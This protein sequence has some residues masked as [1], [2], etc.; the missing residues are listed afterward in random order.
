MRINW[1]GGC[2]PVVEVG[3]WVRSRSRMRIFE[4]FFTTKDLNGAGL[5]LWISEEMVTRHR[6]CMAVPSCTGAEH[7]GTSFMLFPPDE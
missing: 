2:L 7:H 6:G 4:P 1:I 3:E 5:G